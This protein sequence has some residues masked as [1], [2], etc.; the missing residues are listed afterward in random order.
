[1]TN[2][3]ILGRLRYLFNYTD[4]EVVRLFRLAHFGIQETDVIHWLKK[5]DDPDYVEMS[6]KELATFL[7]GLIV[8]KRGEREGATPEPESYLT[9]NMILKKLK[10]ALNLKSEDILDLF[11]LMDKKIS[12]PELSAFFRHP[13]HNA[14]R[15]LM[16]QYLRNFLTALQKKSK[17]DNGKSNSGYPPAV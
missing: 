1:M 11:A 14:Y 13:D 8:E 10:I 6:D 7:N 4:A 16:D 2:N 3:D 9:N 5:E 15:P 12:K 17:L